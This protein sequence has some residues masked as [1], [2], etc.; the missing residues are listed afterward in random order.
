[1][2]WISSFQATFAFLLLLLPEARSNPLPQE[3]T[4]SLSDADIQRMLPAYGGDSQNDTLNDRS[5]CFNTRS[6]APDAVSRLDCNQLL[7]NILVL[8]STPMP[9]P[10]SP[11]TTTFPRYYTWKS[12][13]ISLYPDSRTSYDIFSPLGI[14]R[15]AALVIRD[16]V[17]EPRGYL[18]GRLTIGRSNSFWV[19]VGGTPLLEPTSETATT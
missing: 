4:Q 15:V 10:W 18:G 8:P 14:A 7:F 6:S 16:C 17:T 3:T 19:S 9:R 11:T 12:C 5:Q 13:T 2:L 1:M